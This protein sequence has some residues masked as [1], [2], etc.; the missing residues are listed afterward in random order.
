MA[1]IYTRS[2]DKG[3]TSLIG[4]ERVAKDDLRVEAYGTVD[5]L[6]A[7][8]ALLT[9]WAAQ[10]GHTDTVAFLDGVATRLMKI[11]ALLAV[12]A[13]FEGSLSD[14]SEAE[15][16]ELESEIDRL[17]EGLPQLSYFT[18]PG[19]APL[20]SQCHICRTVSRRAE[21]EALRA[22]REHEVD[23]AVKSWLNRLSDYFYLLGRR[24]TLALGVEEVEWIP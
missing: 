7:H 12:G 21:R 15:V 8:I 19:G 16:A 5:E 22:D 10:A 6:G 20:V 13:G 11:E 9:D 3:T 17:S 2:G 18:I 1:R 14:I 4:G 24:L 23:S